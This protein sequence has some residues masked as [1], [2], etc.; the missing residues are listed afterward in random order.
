MTQRSADTPWLRGRWR[1][2]PAVDLAVPMP[3]RVVRWQGRTYDLAKVADLVDLSVAL[4]EDDE[5]KAHLEY[6]RQYAAAKN[7]EAA[8][9]YDLAGAYQRVIDLH[10]KAAATERE[11]D[12]ADDLLAKWEKDFPSRATSL[13]AHRDKYDL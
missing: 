13:R 4:A 9:N 1:P 2:A 3:D 12:A 11:P 7:R 5:Q 6:A 8:A 10:E